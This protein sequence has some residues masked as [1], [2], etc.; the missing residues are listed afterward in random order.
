TGGAGGLGLNFAEEIAGKVKTPVLV[1]TGRSA[2][3]TEVQDQL[4]TLRNTGARV[5]Y[6]QSD[7]TRKA[8][9]DKLV[10]GIAAEF[11]SLTGIIHSA[12][13]IRDNFILNKTSDEFETVLAPKVAGVSCLDDASK[14]LDLDFFVMFS[15]GVGAVG[16]TGQ[17]DYACANAYMDT[18]AAYRD[19]LVKD[20]KRSGKTLSINW[21]PWKSGGMPVDAV[22]EKMMVRGSGIAAM[23]TETGIRAFHRAFAPAAP[24]VMPVSGDLT[25]IRR[26]LLGEKTVAGNRGRTSGGWAPGDRDIAPEM[27]SERT[28]LG[29]KRLFAEITRV[30]IADIGPDEPFESFGIDSFMIARLNERLEETFAE[31]PKTLFYEYRTIRELAAYFV[32]EYPEDCME[33]GGL[34][35]EA[36]LPK[37]ENTRKNPAL[38]TKAPARISVRYEG[39]HDDSIA[40][41]PIA[42]IGISGRFPL[43]D[44]LEDFWDNLRTGRDC[45]REIPGERW[46]LDGFFHPDPDTAAANG[47]SYCKWGGFIDGFADFDPLFFN[48]SPKEAMDLD[49][50]ERLFL[51]ACWEVFE[52]AGYTKAR[53]KESC[54]GRVGVFAG[55]TKTGYE[56]YGPELWQRGETAHPNTSFSSLANRVS[57]LFDFK[58]PSLPVDTMCSSS[59]TAIH[60]ACAHL[61]RGECDMAV[62]GGVNLYLHPSTYVRLCSLRMLT[63]GNTNKS[64]GKGGDGFLP[65]EG[66]GAVLLKPL[67]RALADGDPIHAVI[68]GTG[69][70]H[71]GKTSGY[72]IPS[73]VAQAELI[74][75]VM[76]KAGVT[77]REISYVETHGTGTELGDPIEIAGLTRAFGSDSPSCVIGSAKSNIGHLE[78]SAGI[79]GLTKIILQMQH[80]QI[81][82]S[83][84]ARELNPNIDFDKTPFTVQQDLGEWTRPEIDGKERPRMAGLSSF[85]AGGANAHIILEEFRGDSCALNERTGERSDAPVIFVLSAKNESRLKAYAVRMQAWLEEWEKTDP[86]TRPALADITYTLQTGREP[87]KVRMAMPADSATRIKE[88]LA[89]YIA[90]EEGIEDVYQ[91][92]VKGDSDT[93]ALFRADED[94]QDAVGAWMAKGKYGRLLDFWV[95]GLDVNWDLLYEGHPAPKRISLPTYPFAQERYW[96]VEKYSL[97]TGNHGMF[98]PEFSP[99]NTSDVSGPLMTFEEYLCEGSLN[100]ETP[101]VAT[102]RHLVCILENTDLRD[103]VAA[104]VKRL[105]PATRVSFLNPVSEAAFTDMLQEQGAI[106]AVWYMAALEDPEALITYDGIVTCIKSMAAARLGDTRFLMGTRMPEDPERCYP[107]SWIGFE[108]SLGLVMPRVQ[109]GV[110][111]EDNNAGEVSADEISGWTERLWKEMH[112]QNIESAVNK[113]GKRY[114]YRIR[115]AEPPAEDKGT[116]SLIRPAHTY[117]ITGGCGGLGALFARHLAGKHP[118]NLILTGRSPM[119][120]KKQALLDEIESINPGV[121][122]AYLRAD[123]CDATAMAEGLVALGE[124]FSPISGVIHAAGIEGGTPITEKDMD[125]FNRTVHPKITGTLALDE[126]LKDASLDF[127]CY[128]SSSAAVLG[129][130]GWCDYAVGNRFM[131]AYG[132]YKQCSAAG[133]RS[134]VVHWPLWNAGG[135]GFDSHESAATYLRSSGQRLL[136][137]DEGLALFDRLL[138]GNGGQYLALAGDPTRI[139][140]FLGLAGG[141]KNLPSD[142]VMGALPIAQG[143]EKDIKETIGNLLAI[144]ADQLDTDVNLAEF[145]FDSITLTEFGARLSDFYDVEVSPAIFFEINTIEKLVSFFADEHDSIV[146]AFYRNA[147]GEE[148]ESATPAAATPPGMPIGM[149]SGMMSQ[150]QLTGTTLQGS[151]GDMDAWL[152]RYPECVSLN[153]VSGAPLNGGTMKKPCFWIHPLTGSVEP[154]VKIA[155]SM[156]A[157]QP[158]FGIRA[159]G[160]GTDRGFLTDITEM[161]RYYIDI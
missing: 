78:A 93:T 103:A 18:Y 21:A 150:S 10:R 1:L 113:N 152:R 4:E 42:I 56:L 40:Q 79:A 35:G 71:G 75:S 49:P 100:T 43:A 51:N 132:D 16:N 143:L 151:A 141:E 25:A 39:G 104:T 88:K 108:R 76:D 116:E 66:G 92:S 160:F 63:T 137:T 145:G 97:L 126:V 161:A 32:S 130:F 53:L 147:T 105:S 30:R 47:K 28:E 117:L 13:V 84:H 19:D 115:Q 149:S 81:A 67:S 127:V 58:G 85:G 31:V 17:A 44:T 9:V 121:R 112:A 74:R 15:S 119:D 120:D 122:V 60:E 90:G 96:P 138:S 27:L 107:Q 142:Q 59:L 65:G 158:F 146:S 159:K 156:D 94:L 22:A 153:T 140:R 61:Y 136:E 98:L 135:M 102:V 157:G 29:L 50:Q 48:I 2:P 125:G 144:P 45:I 77:A 111:L 124:D 118:V 52:D 55:I 80:G 37:Q 83:L 114:V 123:V 72:T 154:Y 3:G 33:W 23:E 69:I 86:D 8:D 12:G 134:I 95:R 14:D 139:H 109:S 106:D 57:Y 11:G 70:N 26:H 64:F 133:T 36:A 46:P 110:V 54:D 129:D 82:P 41:E 7:V 38:H 155:R 148:K 91:G 87:M 34:A 68:R 62:A 128:F 99:E 6:R 5:E 131:A 24:Q 89:R 101:G 73:P 20:G